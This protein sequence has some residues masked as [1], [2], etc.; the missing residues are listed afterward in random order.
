MSPAVAVGAGTVGEVPALVVSTRALSVGRMGG[1]CLRFGALLGSSSRRA[2]SAAH[3]A[4]LL[5]MD[6]SLTA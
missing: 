1:C 3:P 6:S 2:S 4:N 5:S